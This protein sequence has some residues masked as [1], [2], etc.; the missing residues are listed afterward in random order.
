MGGR[1]ARISP[2]PETASQIRKAGCC[3]K[4]GVRVQQGFRHKTDRQTD[5]EQPNSLN[6]ELFGSI[7]PN[8]R[9][10]LVHLDP[11]SD[12]DVLFFDAR[13]YQRLVTGDAGGIQPVKVWLGNWLRYSETCFRFYTFATTPSTVVYLPT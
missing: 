6:L 5:S 8:F 12:F 13:E 1:K 7:D 3:W 2:L 10:S 11:A 4:N 9:L